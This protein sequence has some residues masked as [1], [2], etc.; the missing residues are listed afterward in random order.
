MWIVEL[1]L[2][3]PYSF[4]AMA[5]LIT[6][7]GVVSALR[8]STDIFPFINQPVVT[9]IW[10]Y[11]GLPAEEVENRITTIC[12]RAI[13]TVTSDIDH[14]ES[15]SLSGLAVIKIYL[16]QG[17]D[18]G[19]AVGTIGSLCQTILKVF[20]PGITPPLITSFNASDVPILQLGLGSK[21][22]SESELFDFG[23]N[24]I[25]TGLSGVPGASIPLPYGGKQR[26]VMVDLDPQLLMAKGLSA[27]DV[28]TALN[29]QNIIIPSGTAKIGDTEYA[30]QLNNSP[31]AIEAFNNL[32]IKLVNGATIYLKD[33]ALVHDGYAVQTNIVHH[34]GRRGALLNVLR[35]GGASTIAVVKGIR[36]RLPKVLAGLPESLHVEPLCDQS[37]FV[38][39]AIQGVVNEA[40]TASCLTAI[41]I[42]LLLGSWRSTIIV[43][44]SIPLSILC[45][46]IGL[47]LCGQTINTMTLG[48]LALAVGMLVDDATVEVENIHRNMHLGKPIVKAILDGAAQ[49]ATPTFVSTLSICIVFVP[50]ILLNE[51]A[52]SLFVPLGM[53]VVFAM[54]AS[55]LLS[56]TIVPL[57]A[58]NLLT[59]E[60]THPDDR[61]K[62]AM[63][64]ELDGSTSRR[65]SLL[66]WL[67]GIVEGAFEWLRSHYRDLLAHCLHHK[68]ITIVG[69]LV[70]YI[71][72]YCLIP[73]LGQDFFPQ[74]DGGQLRI[75]VVC[76]TGQRIEETERKFLKIESAIREVIPQ[77]EITAILDNIG[78][79]TSGINLAYGDNITMSNFDGEILISL[80]EERKEST[81]AYA[82]KIRK[83]LSERFPEVSYFFQPADIVSQILNAGLPA[84]IDIQVT[85]KK[86]AENFAVA[87]LVRDRVATVRGAVDVTL[88]QLVNGPQIKLDVDRSKA[89][90]FGLTERDVANSLLINLSSSFQVAPNFWVNPKNGV[91]YNLAVQTPTAK[92]S[93][94]EEVMSTQ[95]PAVSAGG[96]TTSSAPA[97]N[98]DGSVA[99]TAASRYNQN[100]LLANVAQMSRGVTSAIVSHYRIQPVFDIYCN[101]Q[102]RDL[103]GVTQDIRVILDELK[104]KLP[105]GSEFIVRG[106]ADAMNSAFI[107]LIGGIAFALV[108][109]YLLLVVNFHS[110]VDP[111]IILMAIP[112][113]FAGIAWSLFATSTSF[114]VP[115]LMGAMMSIGVASANSILMIT[116][117]NE[118][119]DEGKE[120]Q[121]AALNAGATRFRPVMMTA[122]AMII[123]T[124]PMAL[125]LGEGG[126]Q[127]APLGRAV[128][129]GLLAATAGTL[130]FVPV[131]FS[132]IRSRYQREQH[133][134][135]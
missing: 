36:E 129:G 64:A 106:Q 83:L 128:I 25:R 20:P 135:L 115:A 101:V 1:A 90:Q 32:P 117:A 100:Q 23:L 10:S 97:T 33:V 34:D 116:F 9:C 73:F 91:N 133:H 48:G 99:R 77:G 96:L 81:F 118:Q 58:R 75:H 61:P 103:G 72:S 41:L 131:I 3:R 60:S 66:G 18:V 43:V 80:A 104:G 114:S 98:S 53:S 82:K 93:S 59:A 123:G 78:L 39:G 7:L 85:G 5:L 70:F 42:L 14:I 86:K 31:Q 124:L 126:S 88:H 84:P 107:G 89:M 121:I 52:R 109:V 11:N 50:V 4:I 68:T 108:L 127:N 57:M 134:E 37:L 24:F 130:F 132:M 111:L 30:V 38:K 55:Y 17:A 46:L 65:W 69:F 26:Q 119:L 87:K 12:E 15:N 125:G 8:M 94:V 6:I 113:A 120:A 112:G 74:V 54:M 44:I 71:A 29:A 27:Y 16:H 51:P 79:P 92:I 2:R 110:W 40:L 102:D 19:K 21:T 47:N 76:R 105:K 45:S 122:A 62:G 22:L 56:R 95:L 63:V 49:I 28:V 67:H 13:T 35:S